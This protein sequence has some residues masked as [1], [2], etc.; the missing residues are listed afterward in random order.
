MNFNQI[1]AVVTLVI[2]TSLAALLVLNPIHKANVEA[3]HR[4]WA[5]AHDDR[6]A[7]VKKFLLVYKQDD[8][9][10]S[11]GV[12]FDSVADLIKVVPPTASEVRIITVRMD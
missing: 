9:Y 7:S 11:A 8:T 10:K 3:S 4:E 1:L 5:Q 6:P 12:L 2:I